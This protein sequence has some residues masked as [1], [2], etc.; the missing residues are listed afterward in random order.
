M[1]RKMAQSH[2]FIV[3]ERRFGESVQAL[4]MSSKHEQW[5][6]TCTF[7]TSTWTA[8]PPQCNQRFALDLEGPLTGQ[9]F[10]LNL[11]PFESLVKRPGYG[12]GGYL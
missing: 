11:W 1:L 6:A 5:F 2:K 3:S 7:G 10:F 9:W 8:T 12:N 4:A